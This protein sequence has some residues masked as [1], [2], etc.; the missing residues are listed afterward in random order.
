M[1]WKRSVLVVANVT[2]T[3]DELLATLQARSAR[4]PMSFT[5]IVPA[6]ASDGGREAAKQQV[7]AALERLRAA[8]L[9]VDGGIGDG[10]P[11]IAVTEAWD[12]RRFD[13][14]MISTLP[15]ALSK[16]LQTDLPHRVA[17]LTGARVTH[18]L[19]TPPKRTYSTVPAPAQ[20]NQGV[21]RPLSVL[22][23]GGSGTR[24]GS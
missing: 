24:P 2:A 22:G 20:S 1:A 11:M 17:K 10:D 16:W 5:L 13:E 8:G 18:V 21:L 19:S 14:I 7:V 4:E 9:E 15:S 12:P 6:T 3:S 23:W